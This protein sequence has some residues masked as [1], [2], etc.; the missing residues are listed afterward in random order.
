VLA[1]PPSAVQPLALRLRE[2][3]LAA[4]KLSDDLT[5]RYR[6]NAACYAVLAAA[7]DR[8]AISPKVHAELRAKAPRWLRANLR[9]LAKR[10]RA[11]KYEERLVVWDK[12]RHW[13][14]DRDLAPTRSGTGRIAWTAVERANWD[15]FWAEVHYTL[16]E[17]AKPLPKP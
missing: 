15:R 10:A 9:P 14:N 6:Y 5:S 16:L 11:N 8:S 13:Q 12:L 17:N 3:A 7:D 2:E 1:P 4:G